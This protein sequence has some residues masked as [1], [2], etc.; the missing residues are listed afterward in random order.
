MNAWLGNKLCLSLPPEYLVRRVKNDLT[1]E[2]PAFL[3]AQRAGRWTGHM[4]RYLQ[5]FDENAT[6]ITVPRGYIGPLL[7]HARQVG[8]NIKIDDDRHTCDPVPFRF[9]GELKP[10]Q[11]DTLKNIL[12]RDSGYAE[13]PTGSG[14]T[15][16]ALAAIAARKQPTLVIVHN[17]ELLRQWQDRIEQFLNIPRQDIGVI[18]NGEKRIGKQITVGIVNSIY[19]ISH[20]IWP[21]FGHVVIDECHKCPARTFTEA[22]TAFP[23]RYLLGLSATP[24]RRDGLTKVIGFYLGPK[25]KVAAKDVDIIKEVEVVTRRMAL[26]PRSIPQTIILRYYRNCARTRT[27]ID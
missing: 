25:V 8:I 27:G 16:V 20:Q 7:Y 9:S 15:V 18:G 1:I 2:N 23:A 11:N 21:Y 22:V 12:A 4:Q 6:G 3:E 14:K 17:K 5:Y 24:W 10:Y 19:K 13:A 26:S